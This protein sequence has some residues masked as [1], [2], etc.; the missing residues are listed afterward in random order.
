MRNAAGDPRT[1]RRWGEPLAIFLGVALT[2]IAY[3]WT[4]FAV[5]PQFSDKSALDH[6]GYLTDAFISGQ[7]HLKV[8]PDPQLAQL[9]NPYAGSQGIPTLHD[10][11]YF[12][13]H[14]YLYFGPA[15]VLLLLGPWR[16]LT[17]SFLL[18]GPATVLFSFAGFLI[19]T[20]LWVGWK[21]RF[22]PR[23][24]DFWTGFS[25]VVLGLGN[26]VF[27]LIQTPMFYE[28]PIACAYACLMGALAA[29]VAALK[30]EHVKRQALQLG[31]A[32]LLLGLAVGS[33]PDYLFTLPALGLPLAV[34]WLQARRREG[35]AGP[36]CRRLLIATVA[37]AGVVGIILAAYNWARFG[38]FL[39]FGVKYQLASADQREMKLTSLSYIPDGLRSFLWSPPHYFSHFPFLSQS[40]D[41]FGV[42]PWAPFA[43]VAVAFP[44]TFLDPARRSRLWI[45]GG[46]FL[47]LS[48]L[49]NFFALSMIAFRNDRYAIDF[50]PAA[51]W[52]GLVVMAV[53]LTSARLIWRLCGVMLALVA[54]FTL[55][56]SLLLGLSL[57]P[58]TSLAKAL[59]IPAAA[60]EKMTGVRYGPLQLKVKFPEAPVEGRSEAL[61]SM[62]DGADVLYETQPDSGHVQFRFFHRGIGGPVS[63]P[64]P[65]GKDGVHDL[66]LDLGALYPPSDHPLFAGWP[67]NLVDALHRRLE[68]SLDGQTALDRSVEFYSNDYFHTTVGAAIK[69]PDGV[70]PFS[71]TI[72][73]AERGQMPPQ[74]QV[75]PAKIEGP[76]RITLRFPDFT[77]IYGEPLV[78]TGQS[79]AGDLVYVT[80]LASGLVRFGHDCWNHGSVETAPVSFDP[81]KEQTVDVDMG[82]MSAGPN[83]RADGE[84]RFQLRFNGR[85]LAS[86][87]RPFHPS[88]SV[89]V[90][91]GYNAIHAS[92]AAASFTGPE[93]RTKTIP[94][95]GETP[96]RPTEFGYADLTLKFPTSKTGT[97]EPLLAYGTQNDAQSIYVTYT[98]DTHV[99]FGYARM[100]KPGRLGRAIEVDY[101]S[102]HEVSVSMNSLDGPG[103]PART[104]V[105]VT[106][107]GQIA[108]EVQGYNP[109]H[110]SNPVSV[111]VNSAGAPECGPQFNGTVILADLP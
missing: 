102:S 85:L 81:S 18:E 28:V 77:A 89:D 66:E 48:C 86:M 59:N 58:H 64:L 42:V 87:Y 4:L 76:I 2:A 44:L 109:T 19:G 27:F 71:G 6:Y 108:L 54:S 110:L 24:P 107:D 111:G 16:L 105:K 9:D 82:S 5:N 91:F 60:L 49:L 31:L 55:V 56:H 32:S 94:A 95:F 97:S 15:P 72:V 93:F 98:D 53:A 30:S 37:P 41:A 22:L 8:E 99:A 10:A 29:V 90:V 13:G 40:A 84:T 79:G 51:T 62:A 25:I 47:L 75:V 12:N 45:Y 61:L 104:N 101:G 38:D 65:I 57:R 80:Y 43:L 11:T 20:A 92:T 1:P 70:V 73:S 46:G 103:A 52:L 96:H 35:P 50:L 67:E 100:G 36:D 14:Y 39:E 68:V 69:T 3:G 34:L 21:R 88:E 26:Y 63:D 17:G 106:C 7:L 74:A 23:L 78:S 33:R 83:D